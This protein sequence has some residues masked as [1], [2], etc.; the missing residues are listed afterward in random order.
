MNDVWKMYFDERKCR[1]GNGAYVIFISLNG[2][3][4]IYSIRL[5]FHCTNNIIEYGALYQGLNITRKELH[6]QI[7]V[8]FENA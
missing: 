6:I 3:K 1:E 4:K 5:T 2:Q 7:L 8:Y